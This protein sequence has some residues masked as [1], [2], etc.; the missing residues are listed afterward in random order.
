MQWWIFTLLQPSIKRFTIPYQ[1][2]TPMNLLVHWLKQ[3]K[4]YFTRVDSRQTDRTHVQIL[5]YFIH[6]VGRVGIS[7][8]A[9]IC[10]IFF[11]NQNFLSKS[12]CRKS[13]KMFHKMLFQ[14]WNFKDALSSYRQFFVQFM[15]KFIEYVFHLFRNSCVFPK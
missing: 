5:S 8:R 12:L 15:F 2:C 9:L 13:E 4:F 7:V 14:I 11:A 10:L 3:L 6:K 1:I